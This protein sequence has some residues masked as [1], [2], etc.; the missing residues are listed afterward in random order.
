VVHLDADLYSSTLF[1]LT[2]LASRLKPGDILLFD[3]F[4]VPL[5]EY[6]AF[7][8]FLSAYRFDYEVLGAVNHYLH[9][10]MKIR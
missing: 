6:R 8:D 3:E 1:A 7:M 4:A 10:G 5:H 2:S 9:V